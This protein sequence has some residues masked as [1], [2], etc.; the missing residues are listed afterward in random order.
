ARLLPLSS[1]IGDWG[2]KVQGYTAPPLE[3]TPGD[4]QIVTPGY[5]EAMGLRLVSGRVLDERD[6]ADSPPVVVI[7]RRLAEKYFA[8]RDPLGGRIAFQANSSVATV[9]GV[10]EDVEHNSLTADE[11]PMFYAVESQWRT[12]GGF[13]PHTMHLVARTTGDPLALAGAVRASVHALDP[14]IPVAQL[15]TMDDIV[16]SSI[17]Q[18]RFAM[19][20]LDAF[21]ALALL[22]AVVGIYGVIAQVVATRRQ[23]FGVRLALGAS[24]SALVRLSLLDGVRQAG[25]GLALG[26]IAALVLTRLMRGMLYGVTP[27][28]PA[29]FV[30]ALLVTGIIA[31][32]ASYLPARRAGRV[33]PASALSI[34]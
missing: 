1:E 9:V 14:E 7:S 6:Q 18:Q 23:E 26:A 16:Q 33:D 30:I 31:T 10:V 22:L 11:K 13:T 12:L 17:A 5:M 29:T 8:G 32:V 34:E 28:D 19:L 21:G 20:L 2:M 27:T 24:P 15:R 4:W 3:S 25:V